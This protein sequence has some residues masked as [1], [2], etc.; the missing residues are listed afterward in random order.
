MARVASADGDVQASAEHG[1]VGDSRQLFQRVHAAEQ[2][3]DFQMQQMVALRAI[4]SARPACRA[5]SPCRD[6]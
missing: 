2:V 3:G 1:D 5:R 6:T 4:A